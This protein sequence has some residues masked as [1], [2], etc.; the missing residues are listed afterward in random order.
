M[1]L[2][3]Y[4][5]DV[6]DQEWLAKRGFFIQSVG[7][8]GISF[9]DKTN[10]LLEQYA[11]DSILFD[12]NARAARMTG[13]IASGLEAAGSNEGG[14]MLGFAGMTMGMNV[15]GGMGAM[16]GQQV[17]ISSR[18]KTPQPVRRHRLYPS[19]PVPAETRWMRK[20]ISLKMR[21]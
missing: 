16:P 10:Q 4:M 21:G 6:M 8:A 17:R 13:S 7:I 1:E 18:H 20:P 11:K 3:Q 5:A 15:A 12:P 2:G 9:D 19:G 14:A